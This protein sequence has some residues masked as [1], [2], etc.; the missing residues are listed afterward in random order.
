MDLSVDAP[1]AVPGLAG[2]GV[3][4]LPA[5]DGAQPASVSDEDW[6]MGVLL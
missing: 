3:P 1:A 2:G 6:A 4:A 5:L